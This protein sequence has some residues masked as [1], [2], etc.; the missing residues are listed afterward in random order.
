MATPPQ[1]NEAAAV[2]VPRG[3]YR[4][5]A[6]VS[7]LRLRWFIRLRWVFV[8][9]A[10]A[11]LAIEHMAIP[12]SERPWQLWCV[13]L[14][15]AVVN[16]V[17]MTTSRMFKAHLLKD[18]TDETAAIR[19]AQIFASGQV[20]ADLFL[21]TLVL[22]FT[23]GVENP[24]MVVY[25]FHVAIGALLLTRTQALLHAVWAVLLYAIMA[26]GEMSGWMAPHYRLL[27][28]LPPLNWYGDERFVVATVAALSCGL[29]GVLYFTLQIAARLD[30]RDRQLME[31]NEALRRSRNA[32][33][34]LQSR[35]SRFMQTAAHQLKSPLAVI[36][37]LASLVH[38]EIVPPEK[39]GQT[40]DKITQRCRDG[41]E[42]VSELLTLA[43]VQDADRHRHSHSST[44]LARV[45]ADT[46][47]R[48]KPVA[49]GK[50][51]TLTW[52]IPEGLDGHALVDQRDANDCLGNLIENAIKYTPGPGSVSVKVGRVESPRQ[53]TE[54]RTRQSTPS[55]NEGF[56]YVR[57]K[58]TGIGIDKNVLSSEQR[59]GVGP[60]F[61]AFRRGNN[62]VAAGIPGTGIGLSI[63]RE[64]VEQAGGRIIVGSRPGHGSTFVVLFPVERTA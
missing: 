14:A 48:L 45:V 47:R 51:V 44:A 61:A 15:V 19:S 25:V 17:W 50:N 16:V 46:C 56:I 5:R 57:I 6:L 37:T 7:V 9:A 36:Q 49:D 23:G 40:V 42:Q 33:Q 26:F 13:I 62:A 22:R 11:G 54:S 53:R 60:L 10:V 32:I 34:D 24:M 12:H 27:P 55:L 28:A 8:L 38:D 35:R 4:T 43:R 20:I 58:D 2:Q 59:D 29:L 63:V 3:A 64:I 52:H 1:G 31:T 30:K 39:F 41:I 21:L 18:E